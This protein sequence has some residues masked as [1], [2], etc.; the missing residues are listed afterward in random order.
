MSLDLPSSSLATPVGQM[1]W[2]GITPRP[3]T[4][5]LHV[6][7]HNGK[8]TVEPLG[9]DEI[10]LC[11]TFCYSCGVAGARLGTGWAPC[12]CGQKMD[13]WWIMFF[14]RVTDRTWSVDVSALGFLPPPLQQPELRICCEELISL[15][16][17]QGL[18]K[19]ST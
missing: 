14:R 11:L 9:S 12:Q 18:P 16:F 10:R 1:K 5:H 4:F 7:W 8:E 13:T 6:L 3:M 19:E 2:R 15:E 17:P